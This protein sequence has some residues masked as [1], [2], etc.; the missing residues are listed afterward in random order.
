MQNVHDMI[1]R[2]RNRPSVIIWGTRLNE[3]AN[4][5]DLYARTRQLACDLDGTGQTS[6][7]MS[8]YS[9]SGWAQDVFAY[10]DYTHSGSDASLKPPIRSVPYL[11]TEAVGAL[12]GSPT[13]RWI[14]TSAVLGWQ[15]LLHA[16]VHNIAQSNPRYAGLLGWCGIDYASL[17]GGN[18]IWDTLKT[19]GVTDTFRVLKPGAAFYQSQLDPTVRPVIVP[20]FFWDFG[21]NSPAGGPGANAMIATNCDRLEIYVAGQHFGTGTPDAAQFASLACPPVFVDLTVDGSSAPELRIDGY[22]GD[23]QV[24]SVSMSADTTRDRLVL[25]ADDK[26]IT[27]DGSDATRVTFRALDAHGNQRPYVTGDVSLTLTGPA[28]L[29]GDNPFAFGEYGGVGGAFVRSLPGRTGLAT[30]TAKHPALGS[31]TVQVAIISAGP[32]TPTLPPVGAHHPPPSA[33]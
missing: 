7:A 13:Y 9:T 10:D 18:R 22:L 31:D 16:Q 21:P 19:P 4:A 3:T 27:A 20:A 15:A 2:D 33:P 14:D 32:R 8:R 25:T 12:V 24:A 11:V 29:V 5:R 1:I 26:A 23:R 30:V 28:T 17:N 6:G